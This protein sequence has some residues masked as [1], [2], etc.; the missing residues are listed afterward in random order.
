M[1]ATVSRCARLSAFAIIGLGL[2]GCGSLDHHQFAPGQFNVWGSGVYANDADV[3]REA[4]RVCPSG[5]VKVSIYDGPA[6]ADVAREILWEI[7][8]NGNS[9]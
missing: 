8:C 4:T 7:A 2:T 5:F 9:K 3:Q 6:N 1:V